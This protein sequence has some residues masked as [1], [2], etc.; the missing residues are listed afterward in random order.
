MLGN[1][2]KERV[3]YH[4]GYLGTQDAA[5]LVAGLPTS[6]QTLFLLE[7]AMERL[8]VLSEPRV[9]SLLQNLDHVEQC[10][11]DAC[12][13][14]AAEQVGNL[15]LRGSKP[16]ETYPDLLE[17][18]Y[19]RWAKRLA[20]VLGVPLYPFSARFKGGAGAGSIPVRG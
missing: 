3:R 8:S 10:M 18:E 11:A 4:L 16:G 1:I 15:K 6:R 14:L 19:G 7:S 13:Q 9:L 20:D 12:C 5:S 2:D 17:R